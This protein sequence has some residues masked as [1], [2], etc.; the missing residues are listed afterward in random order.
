MASSLLAAFLPS[1]ERPANAWRREMIETLA[2]IVFLGAMA[3]AAYTD[4][5]LYEIPNWISLVIAA[6]FVIGAIGDSLGLQAFAWHAAMG[7]AVLVA[8]FIFFA[9]GVF[10][11]GDAKLLAAGALW[12]GPA[13]LLK[14]LVYVAVVGG[15]LGI[16][17]ITVRRMPLPARWTR[18]HWVHRLYSPDQ[19]MPYGIAIAIAAGLVYALEL[20]ALFTGA[21]GAAS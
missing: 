6:A 8:G 2:T 7:A 4:L 11:G 5:T 12:F 19:G 9:F 16:V 21:N 14:F 15:V 3:T 17:I 20:L 1:V 10:G 18:K 13:P